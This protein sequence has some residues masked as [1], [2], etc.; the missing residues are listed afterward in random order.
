MTPCLAGVFIDGRV[1]FQKDDL[2]AEYVSDYDLTDVDQAR[3]WLANDTYKMIGT[4]RGNLV[5]SLTDT[6]RHKIAV[7]IDFDVV[8]NGSSL[9]AVGRMLLFNL[10]GYGSFHL[11]PSS[12]EGHWHLYGDKKMT[13]GEYREFLDGMLTCGFVSEMWFTLSMER[14]YTLLRC[15]GVR[16][17]I[18]FEGYTS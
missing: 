2:D 17:P 10:E 18:P 13:W 7:D 3:I 4:G 16:K 1:W 5:S 9:L 11:E 12:T 14:G 6:G 8:I 15:P